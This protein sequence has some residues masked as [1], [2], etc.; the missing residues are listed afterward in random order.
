[1]RLLDSDTC[2]HSEAEPAMEWIAGHAGPWLALIWAPVLLIAPL[3][4]AI[5]GREPDRA[6]VLIGIG[7]VFAVTVWLPFRPP[8]SRRWWGSEMVYGALLALC[9]FYLVFFEADR[10]S[11]FPILAIAAAVAIRQHWAL[12]LITALA[13]SGAFAAGAGE[14]SLDA[15]VFLGVATFMAGTGIFVIHYLVRVIA[16]LTQTRERLAA[17]AVADERLRFSRDLHD[18]LGHTLS[19]IVVQAEAVRRLLGRDERAAA[20][21]A[22]DIETIGRQALNEVREA[23]TGY[24]ALRCA[25]ELANAKSALSV[26][27]VR[28][29]MSQPPPG[30]SVSIDSLLGRIVR[31]STTNVLRH[32]YA[33]RCVISITSDRGAVRIEVSDDGTSARGLDSVTLGNGLIGLRERVQ[34]LGG[35]FAATPTDAGFRVAASLPALVSSRAH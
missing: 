7:V 20:A 28:L 8:R 10:E 21:H 23:V 18:V 27:G 11:I 25:E 1:M 9:T 31:E 15:G 26:A 30:L 24:R 19:L 5:A 12:S 13:V 32:A 4:D 6:G 17:S 3:I 33:D 22:R 35:D 2:V 34:A 14:G 29:S 16:D